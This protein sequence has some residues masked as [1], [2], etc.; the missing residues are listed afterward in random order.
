MHVQDIEPVLDMRAKKDLDGNPLKV[1]FQA[2]A[3]NLAAIANY[4]M[5]EGGGIK[6]ICH[7]SEIQEQVLQIEKLIHSETGNFSRSMRLC[8]RTIKSSHKMRINNVVLL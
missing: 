1:T 8:Q 3:D 4:K 2:V 6:T 7:S 5:G